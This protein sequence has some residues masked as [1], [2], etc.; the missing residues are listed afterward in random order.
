MPPFK[1]SKKISKDLKKLKK[2]KVS[3]A[4]PVDPTAVDTE[5][6]E[7]FWDKNSPAVGTFAV[8]FELES[9]FILNL[10]LC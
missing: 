8:H 10:C 4:A 7:S 5:W 2:R 1:S 6:W 9:V 3:N